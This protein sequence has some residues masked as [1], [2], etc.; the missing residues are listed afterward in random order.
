MY[1][2]GADTDVDQQTL[3]DWEKAH[4]GLFQSVIDGARFRLG[5]KSQYGIDSPE[6]KEYEAVWVPIAA[7]WAAVQEVVEQNGLEPPSGLSFPDVLTNGQAGIDKMQEVANY[8][9]T[10][11]LADGTSPLDYIKTFP[12]FMQAAYLSAHPELNPSAQGIGI[13]PLIIWAVMWI[14]GSLSA[15]YIV[16][17]THKESSDQQDL[18]EKT[19][20]F[21]TDHNLTP[22][23]CQ[24]LLL[25]QTTSVEKQ[26][27][28][29]PGLLASI[30]TPIGIAI[31][32]FLLYQFVLKPQMNKK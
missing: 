25:N 31:G 24:A 16:H 15:A 3:T 30:G 9:E 2:V 28:S 6:F 14:I 23:Q 8:W 1:K 4:K 11:K 19:N 32:G 27:S 17:E 5:L 12:D 20:K 7:H 21:C 18:I 22:A 29:S 26:A 13:L 10:G